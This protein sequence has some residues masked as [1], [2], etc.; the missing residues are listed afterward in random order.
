MKLL[1]NIDQPI[2]GLE[3]PVVLTIGIFDGVHKGHQAVI[4]RMHELADPQNLLL[5]AVTFENHPA[6]V[7]RPDM[8]VQYLC[9]MEHRLKLLDE[10]GI[11]LLFLLP[12]TA[13]FSR[14]SAEEFLK[15]VY[16]VI[17][18]SHL[19]LGYDAAFGKDRSGDKKLVKE[20]ADEMHAKVEYLEPI[21]VDGAPIS[22]SRIRMLINQGDLTQTEQLLGRPFSVY[23]P[24]VA[25][26]AHGKNIGFPTVN[27]EVARLC[28]PPI[29]VYAV[30]VHHNGNTIN[31]V[32]NLGVAPTLRNDN[33]ILLEAYLF[34]WH[35]DLYGKHI[36]V[37]FC[38]YL[39]PEMKF[40]SVSALQKQIEHDVA[41]AKSIL[42]KIR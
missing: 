6:T 28:I 19:I 20:I 32:A 34:D 33:R 17:P 13:S 22:S 24:V 15:Q 21:N 29:G 9:T 18:F 16:S 41:E 26:R 23:G 8:S 30:Q 36:E 25:G 1:H 12:F 42:S 35:E 10:L 11:D 40:D 39:R 38:H 14:L 5:A 31:G 2:E 4:R 3:K 37:I 7:L 27:I